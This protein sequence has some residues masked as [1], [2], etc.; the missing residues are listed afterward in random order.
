M[1]HD[2]NGRCAASFMRLCWQMLL[3]AFL[4]TIQQFDLTNLTTLEMINDTKFEWFVYGMSI[5][6]TFKKKKWEELDQT[7]DF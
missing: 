6:S 7:L 4:W 3:T 1:A 5:L 2:D